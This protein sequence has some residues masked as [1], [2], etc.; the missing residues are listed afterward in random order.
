MEE[1][2]LQVPSIGCQGC[3]TKIVN[4]LHTLAG[5]EIVETTVAI[6]QLR[7]HYA[8]QE[9]SRAQ[10]DDAVRAIGHRVAEREPDHT[11]TGS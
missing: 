9:V 6:K 3:M 10:I 2:I 11:A 7:L 1:Y 4:Q 5:V 8:P